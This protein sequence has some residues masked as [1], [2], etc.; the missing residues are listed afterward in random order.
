MQTAARCHLEIYVKAS[1]WL[2][3]AIHVCPTYVGGLL[4]VP[5]DRLVTAVQLLVQTYAKSLVLL[6]LHT[7]VIFKILFV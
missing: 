6:G 5:A 7:L 4:V 1:Y 2:S 3:W